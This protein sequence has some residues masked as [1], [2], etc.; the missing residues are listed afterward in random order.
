M[1]YTASLLFKGLHSVA[2]PGT[3]IWEQVI[4]L[5]EADSDTDARALAEAMGKSR[6]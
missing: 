3:P 4:V 2:P 5:V 6:A 1:W